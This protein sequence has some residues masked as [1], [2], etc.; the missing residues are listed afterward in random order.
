MRGHYYD[1]S[2]SADIPE[3]EKLRIKVQVIDKY[4][5]TAC[6]VFS[7]K[8]ERVTVNMVKTAEAFMDE[9][10]GLASGKRCDN[11]EK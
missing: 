6:F 3:E 8:D 2:C 7:F 5:G 11:D 9:Y 10:Q 4:F 1:V